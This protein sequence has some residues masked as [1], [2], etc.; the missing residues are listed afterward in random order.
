MK[1]NGFENVDDETLQQFSSVFKH[2]MA[3]NDDEVS[4]Y[5]FSMY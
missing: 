5:P 2:F 4:F 1:Q 3:V